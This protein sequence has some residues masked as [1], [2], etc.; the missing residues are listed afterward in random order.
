MVS[1]EV[2]VL[3]VIVRGRKLPLVY[4]GKPVADR[5]MDALKVFRN[6]PV[7]VTVPVPGE[8]RAMVI[9]VTLGDSVKYGSVQLRP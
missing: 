8:P 4:D 3:V 9:V 5:L 2:P 7:M 1:V 6:A